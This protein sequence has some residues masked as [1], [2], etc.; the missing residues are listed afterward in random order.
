MRKKGAVWIALVLGTL[1]AAG[2]NKSEWDRP[3]KE[4]IPG[5]EHRTFQSQSMRVN[6]GY[7]ICLP[8]EY[9][10]DTARRFPVIYYLHGY[11]G[12]ESSYLDYVKYW[13]ESL[14]RTGP[15]LLV[16]VNGGEAS[17]FSDA[18]DKSVMGET[19]VKELVAEIDFK[20]RTIAQ[21]TA[22]SLHGYSM[23]GFGALKLAFKYPD[24]FG[25]V[26]T[27]GATISNAQEMQKHLGKVYTKMFGDRNRFEANNPLTLVQ[28]RADQIRGHVKAHVVIGTKDEFLDANRELAQRLKALN[29]DHEF[30]ELPG[31]KHDKDQL[32]PKAAA[33]AF[34]FTGKAFGA[35]TAEKGK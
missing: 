29:I 18:P 21:P 34:E 10:R 12:N 26:V 8:P 32:Y 7:N 22:R 30:V 2:A 19:V 4:K 9:T 35:A 6:V 23:G 31:V 28:E 24:L 15:S 16:F 11:E 33:R 20:Y 25:S 3:P 17:F 27:Y 1:L 13:R 5:L 14:A